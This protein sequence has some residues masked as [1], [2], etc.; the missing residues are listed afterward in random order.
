MPLI[1]EAFLQ[2][3]Q[4][5]L[6]SALP[7]VRP[8]AKNPQPP[9]G[10]GLCST[11]QPPG[12]QS[13]GGLELGSQPDFDAA[14]KAAFKKIERLCAVREQSTK[15]LRER[16]VREEFDPLA[17]DEAIARAVACGLLDDARFADVLIR[18]RLSAGKGMMGIEAEL[19]RFAIDPA[20]VAGWPGDYGVALEG[21]VDRALALLHRRPPTA[22]NKREGAYRRLVGKGY[23]SS[24][25]ASA[26][27][28]WYESL[29]VSRD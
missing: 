26:A 4:A 21:E 7:D 24:V 28:L 8:C 14:K 19:C 23:S 13:S 25:A 12:N 16:L 15:A 18:T 2:E 22:K 3:L 1:D 5:K 6:D 10:A 11:H 29:P 20:G 9:A 27:R 17:T